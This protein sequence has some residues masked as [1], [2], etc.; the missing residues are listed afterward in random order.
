MPGIFLS[1]RRSDSQDAAGRIFDRLTARFS[2]NAVFKDVDSIPLAV[3]FPSVLEQTL[4]DSDVVLVL[5]GPTWL[6]CRDELG[7][8]RL[9]DPE[10]F[11]RMEVETALRLGTPT[12]PV[13][14]SHA[15]MPRRAELPESMRGLAE[16]NGQAVRPDPDFHRDM[17]RLIQQLDALVRDRTEAATF[18]LDRDLLKELLVRLQGWYND[19]IQTAAQLEVASDHNEARRI[20]FLYVNTRNFL[21]QILSIRKLLPEAGE[22][23]RLANGIDRFVGF[24]T[25]IADGSEPGSALCR[26]ASFPREHGARPLVS[27]ESV[28]CRP[29]RR[30]EG[31]AAPQ[32]LNL[33]DP[34]QLLAI[35]NALQMLS[36][37][38]TRLLAGAAQPLRAR[39]ADQPF[40]LDVQATPRD[41]RFPGAGNA[42]GQ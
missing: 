34:S 10:D 26:P 3:R 33:D 20:S 22:T 41:A 25:Y 2:T 37:E 17:D 39:T 27:P 24:L 9:D 40:P 21:P 12:V 6:T 19:I 35:Q 42:A 28:Y 8:A 38:I 16:R 29:A 36:D 11:V 32:D 30:E 14:V 1:Y 31:D 18:P 23:A 5:I 4:R 15:R 13:T 7:R